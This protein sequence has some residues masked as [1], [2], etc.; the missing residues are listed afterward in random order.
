MVLNMAR[1]FQCLNWLLSLQVP[2]L[3]TSNVTNMFGF[4]YL[5]WLCSLQGRIVECLIIL[6]VILFQCLNWL[7]SLQ[8]MPASME[9]TQRIRFNASIGF[10]H[11]K[12]R[13]TKEFVTTTTRFNASIGFGHC[14]QM[15]KTIEATRC[16]ICFNASIGFAHCKIFLPFRYPRRITKFQCLNWLCSLQVVFIVGMIL[17]Y[18]WVSMPQLALLTASLL[19]R[20]IISRR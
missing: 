9:M 20:D 2:K 12:S 10:A 11:C 4:Q 14:K 5:N 3:N 6:G 17:G 13:A 19:Y 15:R 16:R 8:A 18:L 1:K 7:C